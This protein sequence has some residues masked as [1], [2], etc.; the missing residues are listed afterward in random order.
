M[1]RAGAISTAGDLSGVRL[2]KEEERK[3]KDSPSLA[4]LCIC[5]VEWEEAFA[6][7]RDS[8]KRV[9][10]VRIART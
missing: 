6:R 4:L 8:F 7:R 1:F 5:R 10:Q 2:E 9:T 3:R